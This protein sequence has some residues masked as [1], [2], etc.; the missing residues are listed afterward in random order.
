LTPAHHVERDTGMIAATAGW[1]LR[2]SFNWAGSHVKRVLP[3]INMQNTHFR[4]IAAF[5]RVT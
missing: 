3:H 2:A 4:R 5:R 1:P